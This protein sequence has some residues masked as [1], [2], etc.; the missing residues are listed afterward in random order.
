M[1]VCVLESVEGHGIEYKKEYKEDTKMMNF[2]IYCRFGKEEQR[3]DKRAVSE[4]ILKE[5][6]DL[7]SPKY[8]LMLK[9]AIASRNQP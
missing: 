6:R 5:S 2:G 7:L 4:K 8:E 3:D 1:P 9:H